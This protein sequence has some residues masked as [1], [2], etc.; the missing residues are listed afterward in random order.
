M[1]VDL[2]FLNYCNESSSNILPIVNALKC[3]KLLK[4][5]MSKI[6]YMKEIL[7]IVKKIL[8]IFKM[9]IPFTG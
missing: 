7:I 3:S 4:Y 9:N 2:T 5:Q 1:K 8:S 6:H